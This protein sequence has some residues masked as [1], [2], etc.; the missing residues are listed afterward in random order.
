MLMS[1]LRQVEYSYLQFSTLHR[2]IFPDYRND[3]FQ[4]SISWKRDL[5]SV[6]NQSL[7]FY[8]LDL[9]FRVVLDQEYLLRQ[10]W[11]IQDTV[12]Q[13]A[14]GCMSLRDYV[15]NI[16]GF[17][18]SKF[19]YA[20]NG[21]LQDAMSV[22]TRKTANCVG[23]SNLVHVLFNCV[24]IGN[25]FVKGFY[26]KSSD[27]DTLTPVPHKWVELTLTNGYTFFYDPQHQSFTSGYILVE[28]DVDFKK[29]RR[30]LVKLV[31]REVKMI[32]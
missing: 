7:N 10:P 11:E 6:A 27:G 19:A 25:R 31:K 8:Q 23:Y 5:V 29:I 18:K 22:L 24:G 21:E 12:K 26:L 15:D 3:N 17:L 16:S 13:L 2:N 28:K 9:N 30:F 4:Q 32:N 14:A 20:D 1:P